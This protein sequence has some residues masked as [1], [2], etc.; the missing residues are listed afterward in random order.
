MRTRLDLHETLSN[1]E[2][3]RACYFSPPEGL[4]MDYPCIT[5]HQ[6]GETVRFADNIPYNKSKCYLITVID[7]DPDSEIPDLV[8]PLPYCMSERV[9]SSDGMYHF[10]YLIFI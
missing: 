3:V 10:V 2:G 1:L 8:S 7:E 6:I 4:D 9:F 5:Y